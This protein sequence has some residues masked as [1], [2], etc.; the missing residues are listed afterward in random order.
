MSRCLFPSAVAAALGHARACGD[1]ES[2]REVPSLSA[3][4]F[5]ITKISTR[6]T[7]V[8]RKVN[9]LQISKAE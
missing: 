3:Q 5:W 1:L 7:L 4:Y 2:L 6:L 8:L 9:V